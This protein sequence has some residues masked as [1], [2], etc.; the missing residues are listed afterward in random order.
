M[1]RDRCLCGEKYDARLLRYGD[2]LVDE[3]PVEGDAD[4]LVE[5]ELHNGTYYYV[6]LRCTSDECGEVWRSW[7]HVDDLD[8]FDDL[9]RR[10]AGVGRT[11]AR[12]SAFGGRY[13]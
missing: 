5:D 12:L 7:V 13:G 9:D 11:Q 10:E 3:A 2:D 8:E 6:L 4:D 1:T